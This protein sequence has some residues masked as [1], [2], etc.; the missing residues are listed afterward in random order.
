MIFLNPPLGRGRAGA[1][2]GTVLSKTDQASVLHVRFFHV[3]KTTKLRIIWM[4]F[5]T[6]MAKEK[7]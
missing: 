6:I 3:I 2:L 5:P 7:T 1:G 4:N